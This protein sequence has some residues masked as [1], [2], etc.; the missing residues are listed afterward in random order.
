MSYVNED[1][2]DDDDDGMLV[3]RIQ[4]SIL[5]QT[6]AG[7]PEQAVYSFQPLYDYSIS[8]RNLQTEHK[9]KVRIVTSPG[10][11]FVS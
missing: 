1:N 5:P 10:E 6:D 11:N 7:L 8:N 3:L 2:D 9:T 4:H